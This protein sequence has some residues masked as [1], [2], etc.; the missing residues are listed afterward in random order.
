MC[1]YECVRQTWAHNQSDSRAMEGT[2]S[3]LLLPV[4]CLSRCLHFAKKRISSSLFPLKGLI[5]VIYFLHVTVSVFRQL[6]FI[7]LTILDEASLCECSAV[8]PVYTLT[9]SLWESVWPR[10]NCLL[11]TSRFQ[12][13]LL[14]L[15]S[16]R[17]EKQHEEGEPE[18]RVWVPPPGAPHLAR[19]LGCAICPV[20]GHVSDHT[21][22]EPAH[23]PAHQATPL[24]PHPHVL[25]QPLGLHSVSFSSVTVPKIVMNMQMQDQ[26]IPYAGCVTQIYFFIFLL[27]LITFSLQWWP[28]TGMWPLSPST[29]CHHHEVRAMYLLA[30]SWLLS[31]AD[32]LIHTILLALMSFCADNIIPWLFCGLAF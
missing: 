16:Q 17:N 26:S 11:S 27:A 29:L 14:S 10:G 13:F 1:E 3:Y 28:M 4:C 31:C 30:G 12:E 19:A 22:G 15:Y 25:P 8:R 18:P 5:E 7:V 2:L 21:A 9:Q 32:A 24:P 20:P 23:H 6:N